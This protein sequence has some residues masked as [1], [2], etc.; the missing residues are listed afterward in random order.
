MGLRNGSVRSQPMLIITVANQHRYQIEG[1]PEED[2]KGPSIWDTFTKI[3]GKIANG[4]SGDVACDSYHRTAEDIAL[5]KQ[6][7]AMAYR[8][9]IAWSRVIPL[10][11]RND[12]VNQKGIDFYVK[13]VDDLLE[14]GITPLAT[15]YHWDMPDELDKRYGGPLNK[16]EF[17][18]DFAN[19]A[20]VMFN[21]LPK[22]KQWITFNEPWCTCIIGYH[23]GVFAPGHTSDRNKSPVGDSTREPWIVGHSLLIAHAKAVKVYREE[24][25]EKDGGE[26]GITLNGDWADP[27]DPNDAEDVKACDRKIEFAIS[28]FADPVYYGKYP[29]SMIDQ[30]GDRLPTFTKEESALVKGS[31]DFYG[32]NHYC[33]NYIK[34]KT[35]PV[36]DDDFTGHLE[37]LQ[38][39]KD[40]EVIGPETQSFWLRPQ[41]IGFRKLLKWLSDRYGK[42]KIY[43]TENGTSIK[44]ENDLT[45]DEILNDEFRVKYFKDY[46]NAM[47][48]AY[49]QDGVNVRAYMAWSLME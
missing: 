14:A 42:P 33:G 47:A 27:W 10:G 36:D 20:R 8:F 18:A 38:H 21:A 28:W 48:E 16:D 31:N 34:H 49:A 40:G 5:L 7:G 45:K 22:V 4:A 39:N 32:M 2:G 43:V 15:L 19:Y 29:Q 25:K 26:I 13:F 23:F 35:G 11:G 1:A 12:P 6:T 37:I 41:P 24:F 44:G 17:A 30:L 46:V 9:S 3:P